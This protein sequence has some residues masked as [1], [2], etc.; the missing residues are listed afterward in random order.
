MERDTLDLPPLAG[1]WRGRVGLEVESRW[2]GPGSVVLSGYDSEALAVLARWRLLRRAQL[3]ALANLGGRARVVDRLFRLGLV[4]RVTVAGVGAYGLSGYA[5]GKL[6]VTRG[7]WTAIQGLKLLAANRLG[8]V[9][10]RALGGEWVTEPDAGRAAE[11]QATGE[12]YSIYV[13]R[14]WPGCEGEALAVIRSVQGRMLVLAPRQ[15]DAVQL[16]G[17]GG[18]GGQVRWTWDSAIEPGRRVQFWRW[19]GSG[20]AA[21]E[22]IAIPAPSR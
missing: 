15:D 1:D 11:W 12:V 14:Y 4:D 3:D 6:G 13:Y 10:V 5:A 21:A 18:D 17:L 22:Q 20:L 16:A 7:Q 9:L 19:A 2:R 8:E